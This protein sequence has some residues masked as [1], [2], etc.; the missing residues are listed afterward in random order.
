MRKL[1]FSK[2]LLAADEAQLV[3]FWDALCS[4]KPPLEE[5]DSQQ[6]RIKDQARFAISLARQYQSPAV[7]VEALLAAAHGALVT[8]LAQTENRPG[9]IDHRLANVLR[10]AMIWIASGRKSEK[11]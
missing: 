3:A 4:G 10:E 9:V 6:P 5:L 11:G 8:F 2:P 1:R 7:G